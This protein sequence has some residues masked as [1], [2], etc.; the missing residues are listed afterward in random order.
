LPPWWLTLGGEPG[1]IRSID[2][3]RDGTDGEPSRG[4]SVVVLVFQLPGHSMSVL[5]DSDST[6]DLSLTPTDTASG[7]AGP[8]LPSEGRC[9]AIIE[10]VQ[11]VVDGGRFP[12]KRVVGDRV[13]ISADIF[14]DGHDQLAAVVLHR[15]PGEQ[16]W[17]E[18]PLHPEVNDAW[19]AELTLPRVGLHEFM[20]EAWVDR[21]KT[22]RHDLSRRE[23]AGDIAV[24]LLEGAELFKAAAERAGGDGASELAARGEALADTGRDVL[25]RR[26]LALEP[27]IGR[28]ALA[29]GDRAF[30]QRSG[31]PSSIRVDDALAGFST[32]YEFF[33]RS[34]L[35]APG[36][37]APG[38]DE[39]VPHGTFEQAIERL[40]YIAD[41][42]FDVVYL[43]PIHPIGNAHR[44]GRNNR[45]DPGPDDV[46]VCWAIGAPEG[47]HTS[48]LPA[49]GTEADFVAFVRAAD[50][51]S[52]QIALDIAFQCSPDHPWVTEH[53][54]WFRHRP[55]GSIQYAENPPKKYQDIYPIDFESEDWQGLWVAL[56]DV[57]LYWIERGVRVFRVD[58][59][60]TKAYP[61]WEWCIGEVKRARPDAIFLAEAFT[62]PK[63]MHRL[64]KVGFTQSYT[65]FTWRNGREELTEYLEEV[66]NGPGAEYFRPNFWPNTPDILH[67]TLQRGGLEASAYRYVLA[68]TMSSNTGIY[69]P[70]FELGEVTPRHAGSEEYLDSEKYQLRRWQLEGVNTIAP[71]IR[72]VNRIRREQP[73]LQESFNATVQGIDNPALLCFSKRVVRGAARHAPT[74]LIV[75]NLDDRFSQ[76]GWTSLDLEALGLPPGASF[77]V[78]DLLSGESHRWQGAH[79]YVQ[80]HPGRQPAHVFVIRADQA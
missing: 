28:L 37:R 6:Q 58:N 57:F 79:N 40:P 24:H 5:T 32:W 16:D 33:P 21:F 65:Y 26:D 50:E 60:H 73:A 34:T 31:Q 17:Q 59:P 20:I 22:W 72:Q 71:L 36:E 25:E 48:V 43:P 14:T 35:A 41:L 45:L 23:D 68:A 29:H 55:D 44:K 75:V 38:G 66:S 54:S 78:E 13:R 12:C 63:V 47:G 7:P 27:G 18:T 46:G 69:G 2:A 8:A 19:F 70:V 42:G 49:L 53:P 62:R 64:A 74:L 11:P 4:R 1:I 52:L 76:S 30:A 61:F 77:T 15:A 67:E 9:R 51:H 56:R 39:P 3:I 80:L 10:N